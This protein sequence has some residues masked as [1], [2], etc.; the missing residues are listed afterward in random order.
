[1]KIK[2]EKISGKLTVYFEEPFWIGVIERIQG[3]ELSVAK[4]TFGAEPKD[5][6]IYDF[7][8]KH[9]FELCFS[10]SV[11]TDIKE[12]SANPKRQQKE[13]R[14][15]VTQK[16]VE[17]KSW[18]ALRLLQEQHKLERRHRSRQQKEEREKQLFELKQQKRKEKHKGH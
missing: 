15:Q 17:K 11:K 8:L 4:V 2:M 10:P 5:Y 18:Q 13:A 12:S 7:I 14:K 6:E 3:E 1:M 16:G 9:Y